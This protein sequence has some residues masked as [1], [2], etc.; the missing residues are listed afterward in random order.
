MDLEREQS[1]PAQGAGERQGLKPYLSPIGV[2]A[3]SLGTAIGWGSL[4]VTSNTYLLQ[5]GPWG[6]VLGLLVG[7]AIMIVVARNYHYLI[8]CFPD[9]GGAYA[10]S[11]EV[12]GYDHGFLT[13]WFIGMTYMAILWANATSVPLFAQYFFG[14]AFKIGLHYNLFGYDVYLGEAMLSIVAVIIFGLLASASSAS[15]PAL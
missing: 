10:Y 7:A 9:S 6:S 2:W 8:N 15:P 14:D 1:I 5:A 3:F 4:V 12:F 13:A 11:K